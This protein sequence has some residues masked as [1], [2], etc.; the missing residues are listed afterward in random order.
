MEPGAISNKFSLH[1]CNFLMSNSVLGCPLCC[2]HAASGGMAPLVL[3][4][5]MFVVCLPFVVHV[6]VVFCVLPPSHLCCLHA[7]SGRMVP[8]VLSFVMCVVCLPF[9]VHFSVVFCVWGPLSLLEKVSLH[10]RCG[11]HTRKRRPSDTESQLLC[12]DLP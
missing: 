4:F 9:V 11:P 3:S 10:E 8:L 7:T 12:C 5:V 1:F 2:L 6:S